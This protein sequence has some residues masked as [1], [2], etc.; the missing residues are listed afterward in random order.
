MKRRFFRIVSTA[1]LGIFCLSI[2][3]CK[4]EK[5]TIEPTIITFKKEGE[6]VIKKASND[7][8][9]KSL[10]I[11][12]ADSEYETQTGMMYRDTMEDNQ[13]MLFVFQKPAF[14]SFYMK[15]TSIPLDIIYFSADKKL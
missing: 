12:I 6:L 1:T 3:S 7:S 11:E 5:K 9:I 2:N 13:G 10:D 4:D 15:N 8:I 14:H